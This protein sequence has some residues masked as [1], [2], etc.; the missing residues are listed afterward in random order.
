MVL[1]VEGRTKASTPKAMS[2]ARPRAPAASD[3]WAE[4]AGAVGLM[5]ESCF[6]NISKEAQISCRRA[7][8]KPCFESDSILTEKDFPWLPQ[9][10]TEFLLALLLTT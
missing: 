10:F 8:L 1:V 3:A 9:A 7:S 6:M 5:Q 4:T 2:K